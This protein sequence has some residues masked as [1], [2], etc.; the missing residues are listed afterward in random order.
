M[1]AFPRHLNSLASIDRAL[2]DGEVE[3]MKRQYVLRF[4]KVR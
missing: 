1:K 2:R 4:V 3:L